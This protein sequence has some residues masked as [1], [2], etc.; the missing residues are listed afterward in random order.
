[1]LLVLED[2]HWADTS[3]LDLVAYLAHNLDERRVLLLATYRV[4]EPVSAE[5]VRRFAD[6]VGRSGA[7]LLLELGPLAPGEV[8]QLLAARAAAPPPRALAQ[9]IVARS[10]GNPFFAEE[11]LAAA[12][13]ESGELPRGLRDL[14][15]RRVARLDR[16]TKGVLR[17][18]A[19]AG[20]DVGYPLLRAAATLPEADVRE[21]LRRAV[22]HGV[23]VPDEGRFRFRHALLAEAVY[24]TL[25]PGEREDLHAR[26]ADELAR[27]DPPAAAAELALHWAAAGRSREA[28]VASIA[29]AREAEAIFG[30]AEALA[31]L[32]RAL[33]LWAD[34]PDATA[35]AGVDLVELLSWAAERALQTDGAPRAVVLAQQ[36]VALVGDA[37]SGRAGLLH[38]RLGN[39]LFAAGSRDAGLAE[40]ER[41]VELVPAQPPSAARAHVLAALGHALMLVWRHEASRPICEQAAALSRAVGAP[42]VESQAEA[43]L[44]VDL[45][46]LGHGDEGLK[47]LRL[48]LRLAEQG[49]DPG[50][51][52]F[53]YCWLT[54]VMTMLGRPRESARV[55]AGAIGV[56][57]AYGVAHGTIISNRVEALIASGEW[58]EADRLGAAALRPSTTNWPH[59]RRL[60]RAALAIGRG[61]FDDAR[62]H[63]EA[64]SATVRGDERASP[65]YDVLVAELAL[66]ERRWTD[67]E[68]VVRDALARTRHRDAALIRV[69]L[70]AQGLRAQAELAAQARAHNDADAL[71]GHLTRARKLLT[72]AR[73]A[74][75]AA[76]AV[77]P[78]AAGWRALAEAEHTRARG[79]ARPEA[80]SD[81]AHLWDQLERPPLAAYCRCRQ[82]EA[83][84]AAGGNAGVPLRAAHAVAARIGARPLLRELELL[85]ERAELELVHG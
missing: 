62:V 16:R 44:G 29:A 81:A 28:L 68:A 37:D 43:V 66:W 8:A 15:L 30:V 18:A 61:D 12:S 41:A 49:G 79:D 22:E 25:L 7:A 67:A 24:T 60:N 54:D 11:L 35:V 4:D 3:T 56:V 20:R 27:R 21:S 42:S 40:R 55:A 46:Y 72:A 83:L 57:R 82:A 70:H 77:T 47:H 9:A 80:W 26:L 50:D 52:V 59:F 32:E 53:A 74:A 2:L 69:Q 33:A 17:L 5:R 63:L 65:G 75:T 34:V 84:A 78:N 48:A 19:A 1:V 36:A 85:A 51:L 39:Y 10:Q 14:L 71:D 45:A 76:A 6:S 64:A 73:R 31:H 23:L 58:D 13:D 38:E